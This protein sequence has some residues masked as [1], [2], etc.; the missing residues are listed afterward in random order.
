[1][2]EGTARSQLS[3]QKE[4]HKTKATDCRAEEPLTPNDCSR[5]RT[6]ENHLFFGGNGHAIRTVA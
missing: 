5:D 3:A 4:R 2:V 1:M 6:F